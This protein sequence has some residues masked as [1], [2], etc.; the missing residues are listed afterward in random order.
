MEASELR[1]LI[2]RHR[3]VA[4][5]LSV[6]LASTDARVTISSTSGELILD[7]A[8]GAGAADLPSERHPIVVEGA[9]IGWVDGPRP[10]GAVAAVLSYACARETDKR[11]LAREALDRYRELNLIYDL[12][13]RIGGHL[14]VD[15]VAAVALE[16]AGKLPTGGMGF[17]LLRGRAGSD[18][19]RLGILAMVDQGE[20]EIVN[21]I[22][23]DPRAS[24]V[25]AAWAS[26]VAVPLI[27]SGMRLGVIG[28][29]SASPVEYHA[30][31]LKILVA[32]AS[33][34]A[35]ALRQAADYEAALREA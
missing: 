29:R 9:T 16:E 15:A 4:P 32:I 20:A 34:T 18:E 21:D 1:R 26:V 28:T 3:H 23:T 19:L 10:S 31:D 12:A 2:V 30:S 22:A 14:D 35:P 24:H 33:L 17:V 25:D 6:L 8:G 7:R 5:M 13:D 27:A 11:A